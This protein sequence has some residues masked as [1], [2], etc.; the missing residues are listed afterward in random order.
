MGSEAEDIHHFVELKLVESIGDLG[1]KLHTGRSRNEQIAT[2]LRLYI[3]FRIDVL[4]AHV[5]AWAGQ[6]VERAKAAGDAVMPSYTHLQRAEP[7]LV[8]HWLLAYVEMLLRDASRLEDCAKRLNYCPLGSGAVAG[9]T[10]ALD[11]THCRR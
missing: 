8:A 6:L 7:V 5:A 11:R 2:D 3:R 9:A 10:L 1:L 4:L